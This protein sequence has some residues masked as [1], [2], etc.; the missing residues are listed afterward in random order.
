MASLLAGIDWD[1]LAGEEFTTVLSVLCRA[2]QERYNVGRMGFTG[3]IDGNPGLNPHPSALKN[4]FPF[5]NNDPKWLRTNDNFA[6]LNGDINDLLDACAGEYFDKNELDLQVGGFAPQSASNI[7][8]FRYVA[9]AQNPIYHNR[10]YELVGYDSQV[11]IRTGSAIELKK[12]YDLITRMK[13]VWRPHFINWD[14]FSAGNNDTECIGEFDL[15]QGK[16][17]L[18]DIDGADYY[19]YSGNNYVP[20]TNTLP[21]SLWKAGMTRRTMQQG[22][23]N[24]F[25]SNQAGNTFPLQR[26]QRYYTKIR[27]IASIPTGGPR[28]YI[29]WM[30]AFH[31]KEHYDWAPARAVVGFNGKPNQFERY[32]YVGGTSSSSI[33]HTGFAFTPDVPNV[34]R[35]PVPTLVE[36]D[37]D[38]QT[39]EYDDQLNQMTYPS[40]IPSTNA[41]SGVRTS[42]IVNWE[43]EHWDYDGG[44]DYFTPAP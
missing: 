11:D 37:A 40:S 44:F 9:A 33:S 19:Q 32:Q 18:V 36:I 41:Q 38:N 20:V 27:T 42:V 13:W 23:V 10:L 1:N 31:T 3:S 2:L 4:Y 28:G 14:N 8:L 29:N 30:Y 12:L 7:A 21:H 22:N 16:F 5:G 6:A 25:I 34:L 15:N 35:V 26:L 24:H 17:F 43:I 39:V